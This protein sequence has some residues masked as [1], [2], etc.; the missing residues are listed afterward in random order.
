MDQATKNANEM[1]NDLKIQ[2]NKTRQE[3]ITQ[4]INEIISS[5]IGGK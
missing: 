1:L 2:Y 4:Q 3:L 5:T